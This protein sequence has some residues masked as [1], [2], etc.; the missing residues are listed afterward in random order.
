MA[1]IFLSAPH[2]AGREREL[3]SEAFDSNYV[4][5]TGSMLVQFEKDMCEYTGIK[6]AVA[7]SSGTAALH[8][9]LQIEGV[10]KGDLVWTSSM[11]FIGGASP[12]KYLGA[13]PVF[14]DLD[15]ASW[16]I[17]C[18]LV[19]EALESAK[20][21][22]VLPKAI[23][24]T[25]LYGQ[26]CD[27]ERLVQLGNKYGVA[28][29]S[30]SAEALGAFLNSKHA[31]NGAKST[32]LSFN[33]NK[34]ITTSGGG[35]LL[36]DDKQLIDKARYLST[37]ARQAEVHYEHTEIGYNYRM[38]NICAAIGIGQLEQIEDKVAIRRQIFERYQETLGQFNFVSFMPEPDGARS[39]KW[40]TC[41]TIDPEHS[42]IDTNA[43]QK[44]CEENEIE[45]RPL[46]KPMHMQ[47]V[48]SGTQFVGSGICEKLFQTGLCLPSG[49]GMTSDEQSRVIDVLTTALKG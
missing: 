24:P 23:V 36:S 10:T 38:S 39:S 30:D 45:V 19:E 44:T 32:I 37:Q 27:L 8:L 9:A 34:I 3:V 5:P 26:S 43:I 35:M 40:L 29:I 6:Y 20:K 2:I 4:A 15:E 7:L 12:I 42:N 18:D 22:G 31:G 46:W 33:G 11:T 41:I 21:N 17:D 16:G 1:R 14:F 25:D 47:P 13:E 48:F 28:I 49:S